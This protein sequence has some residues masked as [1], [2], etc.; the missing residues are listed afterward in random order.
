VVTIAFKEV[1]FVVCSIRSNMWLVLSMS[2]LFV[3]LT[4]L[5]TLASVL[6]ISKHSIL[7]DC[8]G[9]YIHNT[10]CVKVTLVFGPLVVYLAPLPLTHPGVCGNFL[11]LNCHVCFDFAWD[12]SLQSNKYGENKVVL[13]IQLSCKRNL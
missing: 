3:K 8:C 9:L 7:R 13:C 10:L 2:A 5:R 6:K 1:G 11:Y 12:K 4:F